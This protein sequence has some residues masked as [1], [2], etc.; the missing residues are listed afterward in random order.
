MR[1]Q[2]PRYHCCPVQPLSSSERIAFSNDRAPPDIALHRPTCP[3]GAHHEPRHQLG[4]P[5]QPVSFA[6]PLTA[7]NILCCVMVF[8]SDWIPPPNP[9]VNDP[10]YVGNG[11]TTNA[12][13]YVV[14]FDGV[15]GDPDLIDSVYIMTR[16][17]ETGDAYTN[18][19]AGT[20]DPHLEGLNYLFELS[21]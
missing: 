16:C 4:A 10:F 1:F 8:R 3:R 7:G 15:G 21:V 20:F 13:A 11:W 2:E 17:I 9:P 12:M 6:A 18:M 14:T 5:Q 19:P